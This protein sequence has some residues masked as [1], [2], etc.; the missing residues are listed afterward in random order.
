MTPPSVQFIPAPSGGPDDQFTCSS[1]VW[2]TSNTWYTGLN[3]NGAWSSTGTLAGTYALVDAGSQI[4]NARIRLEVGSADVQ[5][6]DYI[7]CSLAGGDVKRATYN[8]NN[9]GNGDYFFEWDD[10]T[11]TDAQ[12]EPGGTF[13]WNRT[14]LVMDYYRP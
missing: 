5:V 3:T 8:G 2:S 9:A 6:G 12:I 11:F 4:D 10:G 14:D 13:G 1:F 7:D